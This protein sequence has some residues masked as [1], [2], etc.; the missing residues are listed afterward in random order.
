MANI[1]KIFAIL[2]LSVL[3]LAPSS[4][5][6]YAKYMDSPSID[7]KEPNFALVN[8]FSIMQT[9][10]DYILQNGLWYDQY[11][12]IYS[13]GGPNRVAEVSNFP[14]VYENT[15]P[16]TYGVETPFIVTEADLNYYDENGS[17]F[18]KD[19]NENLFRLGEKA[20][21]HALDWLPGSNP[22]WVEYTEL[23][24]PTYPETT[25]FK[26]DNVPA[27]INLKSMARVQWLVVN[28][29]S[30]NEVEQYKGAVEKV[31][32]LNLTKGLISDNE[33]MYFHYNRVIK[34]EVYR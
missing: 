31:K 8:G 32:S 13:V 24:L 30:K 2:F 21:H 14:R 27:P 25:Y 3:F 29:L 19:R 28:P 12:R 5:I 20:T 9:Y 16:R 23:Q 18:Y 17:R 7:I 4:A 15:T 33:I 22:K 1:K 6:A 34:G 26:F 10:G 11:T